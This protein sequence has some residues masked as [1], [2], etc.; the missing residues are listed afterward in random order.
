MHFLGCIP[1][2]KWCM[3]VVNL[4]NGIK[5]VICIW[6][7]PNNVSCWASDGSIISAWPKT[8]AFYSVW[9]KRCNTEGCQKLYLGGYL[10]A[11]TNFLIHS[12]QSFWSLFCFLIPF[13][14]TATHTNTF[15]FMTKDIVSQLFMLF[16]F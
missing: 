14:S 15:T 8:N 5:P 3:T 2:F 7:F 6:K 11:N 10:Y 4:I 13:W 16:S 9:M 1:V 12:S